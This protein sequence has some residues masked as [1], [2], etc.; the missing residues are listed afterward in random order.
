MVLVV[1]VLV[2]VVG[3]M[4]DAYLVDLLALKE[5]ETDRLTDR[6]TAEKLLTEILLTS[7]SSILTYNNFDILKMIN[8]KKGSRK[9]EDSSQFH[10]PTFYH[11][12]VYFAIF[13]CINL[14]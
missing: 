10:I 5:V 12:I 11:H 6:Q 3:V 14:G 1:V 7:L 4:F 13:S 9:D 2:V 8:K